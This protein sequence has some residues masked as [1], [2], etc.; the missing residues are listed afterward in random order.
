MAKFATVTN[1]QILAWPVKFTI[2]NQREVWWSDKYSFIFNRE[3]QIQISLGIES[4]LLESA[5]PSM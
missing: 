2:S 1:Q 3:S 4:R 5:L